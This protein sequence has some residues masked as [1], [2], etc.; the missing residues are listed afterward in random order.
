M[1]WKNLSTNQVLAIEG[2]LNLFK[3]INLNENL[4]PNLGFEH[5]KS[6]FKLRLNQV[7]VF[8]ITSYNIQFITYP[9]MKFFIY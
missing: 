2:V 1:S 5:K 7:E 6:V 8:K 4:H 3:R 9:F